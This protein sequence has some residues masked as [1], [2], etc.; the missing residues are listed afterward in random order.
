MVRQVG[1]DG[2]ATRVQVDS[3]KLFYRCRCFSDRRSRTIAVKGAISIM[4][5]SVTLSSL[6]QRAACVYC[7][8]E[9]RHV[10]KALVKAPSLPRSEDIS[11]E[12][13]SESTVKS[14]RPLYGAKLLKP[15]LRAWAIART[16]HRR[17]VQVSHLDFCQ[18][19]TH[20]AS[21]TNRLKVTERGY[22]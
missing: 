12:G 6:R 15:R 17:S 21:G 10:V 2:K 11:D 3:R 14:E 1:A 22:K 20:P 9:C 7:A 19:L 5:P 8:Q 18:F 13:T 16:G 4:Q